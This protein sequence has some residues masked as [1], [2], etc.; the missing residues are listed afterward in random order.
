MCNKSEC[1]DALI[2]SWALDGLPR[3]LPR[4]LPGGGELG[5]SVHAFLSPCSLGLPLGLGGNGGCGR[6]CHAQGGLQESS[7]PGLVSPPLPLR[8]SPQ[9]PPHREGRGGGRLNPAGPPPPPSAQSPWGESPGRRQAWPGLYL[10]VEASK[11]PTRGRSL[12]FHG[13]FSRPRTGLSF[14]C[15]HH[16]LRQKCNRSRWQ[17]L[18]RPRRAESGAGPQPLLSSSPRPPAGPGSFSALTL[19]PCCSAGHLMFPVLGGTEGSP[20]A[21]RPV[22][23]P[24]FSFQTLHSC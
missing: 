23:E 11:A 20:P 19:E 17:I 8:A 24:D 21:G 14:S 1:V 13:A 5:W 22:W 6:S 3:F 12:R 16:P 9:L 4:P 7:A 18:R 15:P 2:A 10:V